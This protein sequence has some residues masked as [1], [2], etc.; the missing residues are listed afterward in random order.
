MRLRAQ[1]HT[2]DTIAEMLGYA[3]RSGA[4]HA[5]ITALKDTLQEPAD[6]LRTLEVER[7]DTMLHALMEKIEGGEE[8]AINTA[9]RV[10][11]RRAKLLG[12]DQPAKVDVT[13][14]GE[15]ITL[16]WPEYEGEDAG[17]G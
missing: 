17:N 4:Y 13:S 14:G 16:H 6:E 3:N 9:L 15:R 8:G 12:L 7:L 10:M 2:F 1:G 5:V 11:E